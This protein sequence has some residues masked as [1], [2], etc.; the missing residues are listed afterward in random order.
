[1]EVAFCRA[2]DMYLRDYRLYSCSILVF[3]PTDRSILF[4]GSGHSTITHEK[5]RLSNYV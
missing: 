2:L 4:S 3:S 1:M 5:I